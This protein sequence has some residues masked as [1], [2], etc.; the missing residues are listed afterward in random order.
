MTAVPK[1][2]RNILVIEDEP[3]IA[4]MLEA[5]LESLGI[6]VIGPVANLKA[7]LQLTEST[8]L[9]AALV[10]LNISGEYTTAVA[11]KLHTRNIPFIFVSGYAAPAG[12]LHRDVPFL[13]KPFTQTDLRLA[14]I[15]L[16][17]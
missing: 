7:A 16:L 14:L 3:L 8:D 9:D 12:L 11:D 2:K 6:H 17:K 5:E 15:S 1:K 13:R 10:D 4:M